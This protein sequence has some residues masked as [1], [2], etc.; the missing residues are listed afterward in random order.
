MQLAFPPNVPEPEP[1]TFPIGAVLA[2]ALAGGVIAALTGSLLPLALAG[3]GPLLGLAAVFDGRRQR[4]R[5]HRR[6]LSRREADLTRLRYAVDGERRA[7]RAALLAEVHPAAE[8]VERPGLSGSGRVV[9]G[10][11][12]VPS[13]LV[14]VPGEP[15]DEPLAYDAAVL[16]DAPV[17]APAGA[18]VA[19]LGVPLLAGGVRRALALQGAHARVSHSGPPGCPV[20]LRVDG[21]R[22]ALVLAHPDPVARVPL[23]PEL[24]SRPAAHLAR[25]T[26]RARTLNFDAL[27]TPEPGGGLPARFAE[28]ADGALELDLAADGPHAVV[29]G[30][31][32]SGKSELLRSWVLG[33]AR[34]TPPD[35]L[36]LLLLDF[37][38]GTAFDAL[39]AL[40][41]V[42]GI[43][44]DLDD[45]AVERLATALRAEVRRREVVLR[46][47]GARD[48]DEVP[49]LARLVVVVDE[50]AALLR[51]RPALQ[52]VFADLAARG[53]ALGIS[54]VLCTQR[55]A[56][57]VRDAVLANCGL[58]IAL[59]MLGEDDSR[60]LIGTTDATALPRGEPGR[61]LVSRS[62]EPGIAARI[63]VA[64]DADILAVIGRSAGARP[65]A[66]VL[67]P[68]LPGTV[69]L[70]ELEPAPDGLLV[71]LCDLPEEQRRAAVSW[72]PAADGG[73]LAVGGPGSGRTT[74]LA[75]LAAQG[76]PAR[77]I[78]GGAAAGGEALWDALSPGA[79]APLLLVDGMDLLLAA[80]PDEYAAD[81]GDRLTLAL[82]AGRL[83]LAA[84]ARAPLPGAFKPIASAFARR[85]VLRTGPD[86]HAILTGG[87]AGYDPRVPPGGGWWDGVRIQVAIASRPAPD[88][89]APEVPVLEVA[90]PLLIVTRWPARRSEQ[91]RRAKRGD[92]RVVAPDDL[93]ALWPVP[94]GTP[95]VLDGCTPAEHRSI[96]RRRE[97]PPLLA[98]VEGRAWLVRPEQPTARV[99]LDWGG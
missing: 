96:T 84:T 18:E 19:V 77:R 49:A 27:G 57:V 62:G 41:H 16:Q 11:G 56:G 6:A 97:L 28:T 47:R 58:R 22:R 82:R 29:G 34:A 78:D 85:L 37:K 69:R 38:G 87:T 9:L 3:L 33:L 21:V 45:T 14:L 12:P 23:R 15:G 43:V 53:R 63:A 24:V 20:V 90:G 26:E 40:P 36:S 65:P 50:Y 98:P 75:T 31:T 5:S 70:A 25:R 94:A 74:L 73:L 83:R 48:V 92:V 68:P 59:R 46:E 30:T 64:G 61:F 89:T 54:L 10:F 4:R 71:G 79:A 95:M 66:P 17:T 7:R 1:V 13:G 93:A 99:S 76:V 72:N 55:P 8:L 81:L 88:Q 39:A 67:L 44:T 86:E 91:L 35:R 2:P 42:A 80:M 32:G 60:A 52:D 51:A